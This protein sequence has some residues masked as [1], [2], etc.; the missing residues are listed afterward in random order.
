MSKIVGFAS[1]P[2]GA[3]SLEKMLELSNVFTTAAPAWSTE[4]LIRF[5]G[6]SRSTCYRYIKTLQD[7]GFLTP[8]ARRRLDAGAADHR[9]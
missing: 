5:S 4:E 3:S 6:T 9:A 8:V 1:D 7:A 2:R